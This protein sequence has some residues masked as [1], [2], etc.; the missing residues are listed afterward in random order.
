MKKQLTILLIF[1][2]PWMLISSCK[3]S[4]SKIQS[5]VEATLKDNKDV[6]GASA[7]V[8]DGVVTL[9]GECNDEMS[10]SAVESSVR[11]I[12]GVKD[13]INNCTIVT[14]LPA[15]APVVIAEDDPLTKG[16]TDATK[17]YPSVNATVQDG[18]ITLTGDIKKT[19]LPKLMMSLHTLKPKKIE[20]K[21][22]IK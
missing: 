16:V 18:V 9:T 11:K 13:V 7:S 20:N 14:P 12:K 8:K 3:E 5:A 10:K 21:L 4:D 22:T 6:N 17:D 19:D 2:M 15:P 1:F